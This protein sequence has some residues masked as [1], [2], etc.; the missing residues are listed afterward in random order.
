M[1]YKSCQ[2]VKGP[3]ALIHT[4]YHRPWILGFLVVY[5]IEFIERVGNTKNCQY[6]MNGFFKV[7]FAVKFLGILW[8]RVGHI[9]N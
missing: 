1:K 8:K 2:C 3:R 5:D 9:Q 7:L 6:G 4:T